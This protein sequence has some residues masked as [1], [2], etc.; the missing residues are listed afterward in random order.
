MQL[1]Y[2]QV[3]ILMQLLWGNVFLKIIYCLDPP[4]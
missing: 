3:L 1:Q 4:F 2:L